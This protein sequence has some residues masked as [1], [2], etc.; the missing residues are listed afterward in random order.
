[1]EAV[2]TNMIVAPFFSNGDLLEYIKSHGAVSEKCCRFFAKKLLSTFLYL[3]SRN[4]L[5]GDI[6]AENIVLDDQYK[7]LLLDFGFAMRDT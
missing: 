6:K 5:H 7:P 4:I 1:M 2:K 3:Q